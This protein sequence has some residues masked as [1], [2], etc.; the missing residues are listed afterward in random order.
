MRLRVC[1]EIINY[2]CRAREPPVRTRLFRVFVPRV[3]PVNNTQ[4]IWT[5]NAIW[6]RYYFLLKTRPRGSKL[7]NIFKCI[8]S[9]YGCVYINV[10]VLG[11]VFPITHNLKKN[12]NVHLYKSRRISSYVLGEEG[13]YRNREYLVDLWVRSVRSTL[14]TSLLLN[15]KSAKS[16]VTRL[17]YVYR[18]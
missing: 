13:V 15:R 4:H 14:S 1:F 17:F 16:C 9:V 18:H 11:I 6:K 5:R 2:Y 12:I 8:K 10:F 3:V 7:T